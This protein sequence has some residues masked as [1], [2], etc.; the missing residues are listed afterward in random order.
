MALGNETRAGE[1]LKPEDTVVI[2]TDGACDPNPGPGG[3]AAI[4]RLGRHEKVLT[5]G[6]PQATNNRMEL[7]AALSALQALKRPCR[8]TLHT[9]SAYLQRGITEWLPSWQLQGWRTSD[10]RAVQNQDLWQALAAE[11]ERHRVEWRWVR[12]HAKDPLNVRA[13]NLARAAIARKQM[14]RPNSK[15]ESSAS[16]DVVQLFTRAS[17]LGSTGPGG[18][19][20][21]VRRGDTLTSLSGS[22]RETTPNELELQ[23]AIH[24]LA[25]LNQPS[26]VHVY[27]VSKYLHQGITRWIAAW[28]AHDWRTKEG[29]PVR[30]K[31]L[32]LTLRE[33]QSKHHVEWHQLP[34]GEHPA[35]S[36]Q[37]A[38]LAAQA[39]RMLKQ[40]A[41]AT[42]ETPA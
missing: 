35:E 2:Y 5:G 36:E 17:C 6:A 22:A 20:V 15:D 23:A 21:V 33:A 8:V 4:L 10:R 39:A 28:E 18:W 41:Q 16:R 19:G 14:S 26:Q 27:T 37:A 9:D 1:H 40:D 30:H 12:G 24:G 11:V 38:A 32:W 42:E 7:Q 31:P 29:Q 25:S 34:T 3:W 13:D